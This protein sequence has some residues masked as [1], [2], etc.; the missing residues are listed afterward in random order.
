MNE[1]TKTG[2]FGGLA[3][4]VVVVA[5]ISKPRIE[6]VALHEMEGKLLFADKFDEENRDTAARLE[7]VTFDE[8]FGELR[9]FAVGKHKE[10]GQWSIDPDQYPADNQEQLVEALTALTGLKVI[11]VHSEVQQDQEAC[12]V[13]EPDIDELSTVSSGVGT[14]VTVRDKTNSEMVS[15]VIGKKVSEEGNQRYVRLP[16]NNVIYVV[17]V[18]TGPLSTDFKDWIETDLLDLASLDIRSVLLKD[19][20]LIPTSQGRLQM[21]MKS[22]IHLGWNSEESAWALDNM[23]QYKENE[24]TETALLDDEELNSQTLNDLKFALDE[25]EIESVKKKPEGLGA[26]LGVDSSLA[27]N[28]EGLRSLQELGFF[29]VQN[30]QGDG[31]ELLSANGEM[32]VSLQTGVQYVIRFGEIVADISAEAEDIQ[33]YMVV[34]AMLDESMLVP[35]TLEPETPAEPEAEPAVDPDPATEDKD[36]A[37]DPADDDAGACQDTPP[38]PDAGDDK[39]AAEEQPAEP[40]ADEQKDPR[41]LEFERKMNEYQEKRKDAIKR[42]QVLNERFADWYYQ[43]SEETYNKI[44]LGVNDIIQSKKDAEGGL[45]EFR[46]L[47]NNGLDLPLPPGLPG[48]SVPPPPPPM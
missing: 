26:D 46:D 40:A 6:N 19:Y 8:D 18:D 21:Q 3:L 13:V 15:L 31:I 32:H 5:V 48:G 36:E 11:G 1:W 9:R 44:H 2:V 41:Q 20:A 12:Q 39:P 35:P 7:I 24:P 22:D 33:R 10:T 42:V 47:E 45:D 27:N 25:L 38:Q 4:V 23:V 43:I 28:P 37:A 14:L 29:P 34:T 30:Q 16:D 17:D